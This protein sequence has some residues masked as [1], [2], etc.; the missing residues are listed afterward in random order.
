MG[1]RDTFPVAWSWPLTSSCCRGQEYLDLYIHSPLRLHG[2][3]L[4]QLSTQTLPFLYV[5]SVELFPVSFEIDIILTTVG[6][7]WQ[8]LLFKISWRV[9]PFRRNFRIRRHITLERALSMAGCTVNCFTAV[10]PVNW[11]TV[12]LHCC[13]SLI[14]APR[15]HWKIVPQVLRVGCQF[16]CVV[17]F[18][19][20][21]YRPVCTSEESG[22]DSWLDR[23][24]FILFA[25]KLLS[26]AG[27]RT[28]VLRLLYELTYRTNE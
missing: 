26:P 11:R 8:T 21:T 1:A 14:S 28:P 16:R 6:S 24:I 12:S 15:L 27:N 2:V 9:Y 20:H 25:E 18:K 13:L 17:F 23:G 10:N 4:D 22:F 7:A 5:K 3:M 19:L